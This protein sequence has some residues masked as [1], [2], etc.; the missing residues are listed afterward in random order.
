MTDSKQT[1]LDH[2]AVAS[3]ATAQ[4]QHDALDTLQGTIS[5]YR[6]SLRNSPTNGLGRIQLLEDAGQLLGM[7]ACADGRQTSFAELSQDLNRGL[8]DPSF[9]ELVAQGQ[10][11]QREGLVNDVLAAADTIVD[12]GLEPLDPVAR[13]AVTEIECAIY[14]L[15]AFD[16]ELGESDDDDDTD[17]ERTDPGIII[18]PPA[19]TMGEQRELEGFFRPL[20]IDIL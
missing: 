9:D 17:E 6:A 8:L 13:E 12:L 14:E 4:V 5:R 15:F 20:G 18:L 7:L 10:A 3:T 11:E 19:L 1:V 2:L 16:E